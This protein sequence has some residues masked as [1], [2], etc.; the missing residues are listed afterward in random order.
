MGLRPSRADRSRPTSTRTT[1]NA[2]NL[3]FSAE[4]EAMRRRVPQGAGW[5]G[6]ARRASKREPRR[7]AGSATTPLWQQPRRARLAG[8]RWC[9]RRTAAAGSS[10]VVAVR[11]GRRDRAAAWPPV[12]FTAS[13]CA[14]HATRWCAWPATADCS[15]LF[16]ASWPM[17]RARGVLLTDDCWPQRAAVAATIRAR[18]PARALRPRAQRAR[19]QRG[20]AR[21]GLRGQRRRAAPGRYST[22]RSAPACRAPGADRSICC[23]PCAS[24]V[25]DALPV[26]RAGVRRRPSGRGSAWS[27]AMRSSSPS[28]SSAAPRRALDAARRYSLERYAFGRPIGSFQALKHLM[29]DMLV[30]ID[31][32][33]SNCYFGA[34]ALAPAAT[35]LRRRPR[36]RASRRP[37]RFAPAPS[38]A[39]RCT[40]RSA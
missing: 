20:D 37:R 36:W 33:R 13:A 32:A 17:A 19:R 30:S 4:H 1:E 28:S 18:L 39:R 35:C 8:D 9:P 22:L 25:F 40:A 16:A 24:F 34:A 11:A 10:R 31:L 2:M 3:G 14:L 12:P 38:A 21:A 26:Q 7:F 23:T 5:R 6:P 15:A 27:T 29:A